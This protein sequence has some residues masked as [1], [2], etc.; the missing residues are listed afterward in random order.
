MQ[1]QVIPSNKI[2]ALLFGDS[3][4]GKTA[5]LTRYF[6]DNFNNFPS[7]GIDFRN[8]VLKQQGQEL[9]K[10]GIWEFYLTGRYSFKS[11]LI[12]GC[13][14]IIICYDITNR[15]SFQKIFDWCQYFKQD[16][17]NNTELLVLIGNKCD[18]KEQRQVSSQEGQQIAESLGIAFFEVSAKTGDQVKEAFDYF[19]E[20]L[21][22]LN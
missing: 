10:V 18:L 15:S 20:K 3:Y 13:P 19:F 7:I 22:S 1:N 9:I 2:K 4:T 12:S 14:F 17:N 21:I 11:P 6:Q 16:S 8:K 5:L